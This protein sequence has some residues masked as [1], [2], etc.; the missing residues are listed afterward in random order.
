MEL[1]VQKR[2][3]LGKKV[4]SLREQDLIPAE[5]YGHGR[6]NIHLS[7]PAKE[8]SQLFKEAGESTI[9]KLKVK[10]QKSKVNDSEAE[11][12]VNVLIHDVQKNHLTD[13]ISHVDFYAVKMDEKITV[14]VPLEFIGEAPAVKEKGGVLIKSIQ[15]VEVEALPADLPHR[16]EINL[17]KLSD[18]GMSLC[19]KDIKVP[20]GV[21]ILFDPETVVATISEP[22]KEEVEEKP[23]TVEEVKVEGEEKKAEKE[24]ETAEL[25]SE[26]SEK[27]E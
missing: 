22:T 20:Q 5:L 16:L 1:T 14:S 23:I 17:D 11:N 4:K 25:K 24:E 7:V 8:F 6:A 21:N 2:E 26:K 19:V 3:I 10:S 9:I 27:S 18:I 12:E 15:E 13:K